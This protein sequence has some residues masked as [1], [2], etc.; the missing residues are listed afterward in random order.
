MRQILFFIL[1]I[2]IISCDNNSDHCSFDSVVFYGQYDIDSMRISCNGNEFV[3][4][5]V[6]TVFDSISGFEIKIENQDLSPYCNKLKTIDQKEFLLTMERPDFAGPV[7][8]II[9]L[10]QNEPKRTLSIQR[11]PIEIFN[12]QNKSFVVLQLISSDPGYQDGYDIV[13]IP[14]FELYELKSGK[15]ELDRKATQ[16]YNLEHFEEFDMISKMTNPVYGF[17]DGKREIIEGK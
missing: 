4:A 10:N 17:K 13:S 15:I 11:E 14:L 12:D 5:T 9:D 7:I 8:N 3:F 16:E 1:T 2:S 6:E